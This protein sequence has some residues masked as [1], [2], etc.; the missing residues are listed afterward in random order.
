LV[1]LG[2]WGNLEGTLK[3]ERSAR[4]RGG[5]SRWCRQDL[6]CST[7]L[8]NLRDSFSLCSTRVAN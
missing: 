2:I 4:S 6:G 7:E 3:R 5:G 1:L 8:K